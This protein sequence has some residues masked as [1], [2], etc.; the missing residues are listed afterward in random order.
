MVSSVRQEPRGGRGIRL[1]KVITFDYTMW[2]VG[3][4]GTGRQE[5]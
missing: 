5:M 4:A 3:L 2:A 1:T